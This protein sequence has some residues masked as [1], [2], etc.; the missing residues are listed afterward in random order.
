MSDI[1]VSRE[2][3][4]IVFDSGD[5]VFTSDLGFPE[6]MRQRIK[7]KLNTFLGE[8]FLDDRDNPQVGVPY[9]QKLFVDKQATAKLA[10]NV[11]RAAIL[12]IDGVTEINDLKFILNSRTREMTVDFKVKA[13]QG[14]ETVN[15]IDSAIL[16]QFNVGA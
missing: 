15:V 13:T 14:G 16:G 6:T 5:I 8:Y 2:T 3:N 10:D 12:S 9:Y 1:F 4:D 11:F 7:A